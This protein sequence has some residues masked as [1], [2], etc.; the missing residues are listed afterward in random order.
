MP[1]DSTDPSD[2]RKR[3][4]PGLAVAAGFEFS[5][6]RFRVQPE[7]RYTRITSNIG[8]PTQS[9]LRFN[10]NQAEFLLGFLF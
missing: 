9:P 6:G 8:E 5:L 4:W 3:V 10:Q 2:L 7:F 1:I